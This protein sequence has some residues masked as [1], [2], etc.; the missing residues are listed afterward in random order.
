[1]SQM[2]HV[3]Q[4]RKALAAFSRLGLLA[5]RSGAERKFRRRFCTF[6]QWPESAEKWSSF[7]PG[8]QRN[9]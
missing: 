3:F 9:Q 7:K 8:S 6:P 4:R 2:R 1:M 5:F